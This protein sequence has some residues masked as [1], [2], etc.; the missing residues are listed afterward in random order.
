MVKS[1]DRPSLKKAV[2]VAVLLGCLGVILVAVYVYLYR[3]APLK[4]LLLATLFFG[5]GAICQV[6]LLASS[7]TTWVLEKARLT[8]V[9]LIVICICALML[10][11]AFLWLGVY[12]QANFLVRL[13]LL[14]GFLYFFPSSLQTLWK[15]RKH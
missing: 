15:C 2:N 9:Q 4:L 10:S 5:C 11:L 13:V 3:G 14:V 1:M 7:P 12:S 6:V 8:E